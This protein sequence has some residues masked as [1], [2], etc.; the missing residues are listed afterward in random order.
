MKNR[1]GAKL[2]ADARCILCDGSG[3][4]KEHGNPGGWCVCASGKL[5][6]ITFML[7]NDDRQNDIDD[8]YK[9]LWAEQGFTDYIYGAL[10]DLWHHEYQ[11]YRTWAIEQRGDEVHV[12]LPPDWAPHSMTPAEKEQADLEKKIRWA[13]TPS[14]LYKINLNMV[15][16]CCG[17]EVC[18]CSVNHFQFDQILMPSRPT[19]PAAY[20]TWLKF[21]AWID[22]FPE[23]TYNGPTAEWS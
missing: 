6:Y 1:E 10:N 21:R 14:H 5:D 12:D 7:D 20:E 9:A 13:A 18:I 15:S 19:E 4:N 8:H 2:F 23:G 22:L 11:A 16:R 17:A 3:I